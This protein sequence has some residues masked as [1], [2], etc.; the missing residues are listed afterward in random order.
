M[1]ARLLALLTLLVL[2]L[3]GLA[4]AQQGPD[5]EDD[6]SEDGG[7][8]RPG[9]HGNGTEE[10]EGDEDDD[11]CASG[12]GTGNASDCE[13]KGQGRGRGRGGGEPRP[14][15][16]NESDDCR[17]GH[18]LRERVRGGGWVDFEV[19]DGA[20]L[21]NYTVAGHLV[22]E[23][24]SW[25]DAGELE[26]ERGGGR[27]LVTDG[28]GTLTLHNNPTGLIRFNGTG[29]FE[30][31]FPDG[32][33]LSEG[34]NFTMVD[35]D[36]TQV[37]LLYDD[38][39]WEGET[40]G[41]TGFW[42]LHIPARGAPAEAAK[43]SHDESI[44]RAIED[45]RIGAEVRL[46]RIAAA[47]ASSMAAAGDEGVE[48]LA[49]DAVD[50]DVEMPEEVATAATPI[51]VQV[52]SELPEGRTIVL[53]VDPA[54]LASADPDHLALAYYDVHEDGTET[55]VVFRMAADLNDVLDP[56]DD[57]GQPEY[58]VVSDANGLQVLVS[59]PHW[60]THAVTVSSVV[61]AITQ[62]SVIVGVVAGVAGSV[63]AA[64]FMVWPRRRDDGL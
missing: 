9:S 55:E 51:R 47:E 39:A 57:E 23:S 18:R 45:R 31:E 12:N 26:M 53:D 22:L 59:V 25:V 3:A 60:S 13:D 33:T 19:V 58:W 21:A 14:C 28:N 17:L 56:M 34:D 62:P 48:I 4:A 32:I 42:S 24:L 61:E 50:V 11:A 38:G 2:S 29:S 36:G 49:Y 64:A 5:G 35:V 7:P 10:P 52:S 40:L 44:E 63:L 46:Q 37:R 16:G 15:E 8:G 6:G 41:V 43:E 1:R 54:L 20:G 27:Y 30:L